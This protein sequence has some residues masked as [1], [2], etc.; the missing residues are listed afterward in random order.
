MLVLK[1]RAGE[2]FRIGEEVEIE[3]LEV[4][5]TRV[6]LGITAP[7]HVQVTRKEVYLTVQQNRQASGTVDAGA[8]ALLAGKLARTGSTPV[9]T[10][11]DLTAGTRTP[12]RSKLEKNPSTS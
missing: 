12:E 3:I 7:D 5:P 8:I 10:V 11:K 1:R 9:D 6:K 4:T 2:A